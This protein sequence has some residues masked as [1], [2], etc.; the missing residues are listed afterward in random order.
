MRKEINTLL[1]TTLT[2]TLIAASKVIAGLLGNCL[3]LI[4][5]GINTGCE[6]IVDIF[7]ILGI[8]YSHKRANESHPYGFGR[9]EYIANTFIGILIFFLGVYI[10]ADSLKVE[11][12]KPAL[13]L[14]F[15]A[16][17]AIIIKLV[18]INFLEKKG[19]ELDSH[20]I[21]TASQISVEDLKS[22]VFV[23]VIILASQLETQFPFLMYIDNIGSVIIGIGV[24]IT[25]IKLIRNNLLSLMG[26]K[27]NDENL[28]KE[29]TE[30]LKEIKK[31]EINEVVLLKYG[32]YFR[33]TV[34]VYLDPKM[35]IMDYINIEN[36]IKKKL[37]KK[38]Y[39]I[40]Y[41]TVEIKTKSK[42]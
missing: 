34:K 25:A 33:S 8:N 39:N 9:A 18:M 29:I 37:K 11:T 15:I 14:G 1:I 13:S 40:K 23:L 21:I 6:V 42:K 17:A 36:E 19:K 38:K 26:E 31:A 24:M 32:Q 20:L 10:V 16:G 27:C 5:D 30:E 35:K 7:S 41:V 4:S 28:I 3:T 2:N 22:T 12:V